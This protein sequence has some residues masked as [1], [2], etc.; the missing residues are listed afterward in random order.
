MPAEV[1]DTCDAIPS[2][3]PMTESMTSDGAQQDVSYPELE[4]DPMAHEY[5]R[6]QLQRQAWRSLNGTWDVYL[7][8][9]AAGISDPLAIPWA[10]A[11]IIVPFAPETAASGIG[12]TDFIFAA[13][14]RRSFQLPVTVAGERILLH[15]GAV[16]Y[17]A[18]IWL[19]GACLGAHEGGY[20][21]FT[22]DITEIVRRPMD[23]AQVVHELVVRAVDDP[24]DVAKP[25]GKQ[26][27]QRE[28]HSI[29]YPRTTGIW[30]TVW[31]ETVPATYVDS[32]RWSSS[33][34]RWEVTLDLSIAGR[35]RD[36]L[37][38][39]VKL[40]A[41]G[42]VLADDTYL[43]VAGE[44]HRRI[45][46]SDPGIDD[47]RNELL[48]SPERP[49]LI[50]ADIE[51]WAGRGERLD[52]L[53]SYTALRQVGTQG[54]QFMLNGRPYPLRLVLDQ[55][56]WEHTG[57]TAPSD[58]ALRLD[59][60]LAKE[61]GFNGVRKHQ[62]I[63]DPR[64]LYWADRLGLM[65]WEEMPSAYRFTTRS[66]RRLTRQWLDVI[67]RDS[68]HPCVVAWVPFNESWGVPDLPTMPEQRHCVQALYHLTRTLDPS[69]PVI[70]NDG[71]E[72][73]ATDI[74]AIHDYDAR[75]ERL[76]R[77][78]HQDVSLP[79]LV[80]KERPGGRRLVVGANIDEANL[81]VM[82]TEF[83]GIAFHTSD[84]NTWGYSRCATA[85]ALR[86]AYE[87]LLG[88]VHDI[89]LFA[90]FCYTQ[91]SDTYQEANGL[92]TMARLPKI[93]LPAIRAATRGRPDERL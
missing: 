18:T 56:Y 10:G 89:Q 57:M 16:D 60:S 46:L 53:T 32:L 34:E 37:R 28:P 8:R 64:Y 58:A 14:Y 19:N 66:V 78:Y 15:F 88:A 33:L 85:D 26:D 75:P 25:R 73:V 24:H 30:Q 48:W 20:T 54:N 90:G 65:V 35:Q 12:Q 6:P 2:N 70:G 52:I 13:W 74:L 62:K 36:G 68:S 4:P 41:G 77:R 21:P 55:G 7:D 50:T 72:S 29:W 5:P 49:T 38:A 42:K 47:Y 92:L 80:E 63:E 17:E 23:G 27:W 69:R 39:H 3:T 45:G 82:L 83:G 84:E 40:T 43:V 76:A 87:T 91:F 71:W 44:L 81:P 22:F 31:V 67:A 86:E 93:P 11:S 61:M 1:K 79:K 59:V 9:D 51:L